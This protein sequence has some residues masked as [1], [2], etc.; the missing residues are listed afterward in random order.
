MCQF[1][2]EETLQW[3]KWTIMMPIWTSC[4]IFDTVTRPLDP[5]KWW[6]ALCFEAYGNINKP[7]H[8]TLRFTKKTYPSFDKRLCLFSSYQVEGNS[9]YLGAPTLRGSNFM[10]KKVTKKYKILHSSWQ[11]TRISK[12]SCFPRKDLAI[13][14]FIMM[15]MTLCFLPP[16]IQS[17]FRIHKVKFFGQPQKKAYA[18]IKVFNTKN[19]EEHYF[20][21]FDSDTQFAVADNSAN[22]N[23]WNC[24][25]DFVHL[26]LF[27]ENE[28]SEQIGT[29]GTKAA[30]LGIGDVPIIITDNNQVEHHLILRKVYYFPDSDVN[31][32]SISELATLFPDRWG[33]PD[34][35]GTYIKSGRSKSTLTWNQGKFSKTFIHPNTK[36]PEMPINHGYTSFF[37]ACSIFDKIQN[38]LRT[39]KNSVFKVS[40]SN[41]KYKTGESLLYT[42]EFGTRVPVEFS[43]CTF[44][45]DIL[46]YAVTD[47]GGTDI[48]T[49]KQHLVRP[50]ELDISE[51]PIKPADYAK[52]LPHLEEEE[53]QSI[54]NP[55]PISPMAQLWLSYHSGVMKHCPKY[56]MIKLAKMGI[57]PK[58]LLYYQD[59]RAP[60]CVSCAFGRQKKRSRNRPSPTTSLRNPSHNKPGIKVSTDQ[61][62]SAQPGLV[63]Q[64]AGSLTNDRI[65]AATMAVDHY[66][67]LHRVVLMRSTTQDE[68]L[69]AK[70]S[71]EK[72]FKQHGHKIKSWH[73]DNGRYAEKDFK[74]A[75]NFADQT[76]TF[77][78]VGAHHQNGIAEAAIKK[79]TQQARV[80]LLHAKR[81]W[82]AVI[83]T[84]LWP[85]ALLA[86]SENHNLWHVDDNG[87]TPMMKF[88]DINEF[89]DIKQEHTF[90]CP[91]FV[92]D[93]RLQSS[94]AGPPKW[95]PRSRLGVYVGRSPFHA[96]S[97]ALVLNPRSGLISPQYHVVFDDE[98]S[99]VPHLNS[100]DV[101]PQWLALVKNSSERAMTEDYT[102]A[103]TWYKEPSE[104]ESPIQIPI[105]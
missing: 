47:K 41:D 21:N 3:M 38:P 73:A 42:N 72:M 90:G 44:S 80:L 13:S 76:I 65:T 56:V 51:I 52:V 77:C 12:H 35:D 49:Y 4:C 83:T 32:I 99:T 61:L 7:T 1:L 67:T 74:E 24:L 37:A 2:Q 78:G 62:I 10:L 79:D 70:L 101:P 23:I 81:Y 43:K 45:D 94:S 69:D 57:L 71:V 68:T 34:E 60:I 59:K 100:T 63:P 15:I 55:E 36:I 58:E 30:P 87:R 53:L 22:V 9:L 40:K 6:L 31:L 5:L 17:L 26:R 88:L 8:I 54:S 28:M 91:V 105:I 64:A 98:F 82:P 39:M 104:D 11:H 97:V 19:D 85:L 86:A 50:D 102:L 18:N 84:M 96:G 20:S 46:K 27:D 95:D 66:S 89:P 25:A 75:V 93:H 33:K 16:L 48:S 14:I 103:E 29:I 92:L